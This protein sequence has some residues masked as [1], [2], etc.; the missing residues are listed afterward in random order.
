MGKAATGIGM[1]VVGI[2]VMPF[3]PGLG[4]ALLAGGMGGLMAPDLDE[5]DYGTKIRLNTRSTEETI[6]VVYGQVKV[7][8]NDVF[9]EPAGAH[10][11]NLWIVQT[12]S[13][14]ECDSIALVDQDY[15]DVYGDG[16]IGDDLVHLNDNLESSFGAYVNYWFYSGSSTQAVDSNLSS[17]ISKWTDTLKNTC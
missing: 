2:L 8:G 16:T 15:I 9:I 3:F 6:P 13:E 10:N 17:A 5:E 11:V 14:G 7:G 1:F 4:V 12:L